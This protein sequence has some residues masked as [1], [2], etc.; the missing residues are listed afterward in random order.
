[1]QPQTTPPV[2]K[3]P[4]MS[5]GARAWSLKLNDEKWVRREH[6]RVVAAASAVMFTEG[7]FATMSFPFA[8][9]MV[10]DAL[11][12][13][14]D[15]N[16]VGFWTGLFFTT[17]PIGCL[18]TSRWW[19]AMSNVRGRKFCLMVSLTSSMLATLATAFCPFYWGLLFLR[20]IQGMMMCSLTMV[21]TVLKERV[22]QLQ[23]DEVRAFSLMQTA[24]ALSS[25]LGPAVGG[26]LYGGCAGVALPLGPPGSLA[27]SPWTLPHLFSCGFYAA[28][29]AVTWH[30]MRETG[31]R[32]SKSRPLC[33]LEKQPSIFDDT[34]IRATLVIAAGHS[35]IFT[36]WEVGY[37]VIA[38]LQSLE[39]WS[40]SQIGVTFLVGSVVL[41]FHTLITYPMCV[42]RFGISGVWLSSWAVCLVVL[43]TFP[44]VLKGLIDAGYGG[45]SLTVLGLNYTSQ[46]CISVFQGCNFTTLSLLINKVV[47]SRP[48]SEFTLPLANAW[49]QSLQSLA[50]AISPILT[51]SLIRYQTF[52]DGVLTF[53]VLTAV[54]FCSCVVPML[55]IQKTVGRK[56]RSKSEEEAREEKKAYQQGLLTQFAH[57][58]VE[59][60]VGQ[61]LPGGGYVKLVD[62]EEEG[63]EDEEGEEG[64]GGEP[65][66]HA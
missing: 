19:A 44:R 29:L 15:D 53:D 41:V 17:Y 42:Q 37:P 35:F 62:S 3:M 46:L 6:I 38:R 52:F 10:Q 2:G 12:L 22:K 34:A 49:A 56:R 47:A 63:E 13:R 7:F 60:K 39:G 31:R 66:P 28:S 59:A 21:R 36:G 8:S 11:N 30:C 9:F 48:D 18:L 54:G 16:D 20:F 24:F 65:N 57:G 32:G 55:Y 23:K 26:Y 27:F 61:V 58:K 45:R 50:R 1:M 25:V 51:G 4:S 5:P 64:A 14:E 33:E 40:T 43:L